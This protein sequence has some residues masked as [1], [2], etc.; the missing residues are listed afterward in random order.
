MLARHL[1]CGLGR[2]ASKL[3]S[4]KSLSMRDLTATNNRGTGLVVISPLH[5][6]NGLIGTS[7]VSNTM[8]FL[9]VGTGGETQLLV[10][11]GTRGTPASDFKL[12]GV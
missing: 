6:S 7:S 2:M 3:I 4:A 8:T 9:S 11:G 1:S 5:K 10:I 12:I